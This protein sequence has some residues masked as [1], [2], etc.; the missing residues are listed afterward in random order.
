M[1]L[2]NL[3]TNHMPDCLGVEGTPYF[4]WKIRTDLPDTKQ[5]SYHI[6]VK[7]EEEMVW[8][9]GTIESNKTAFITYGGKPLTSSTLYR[10]E[11]EVEDS[12]GCTS[13]GSACFET[14]LLDKDDWKA[15][16][17]ESSLP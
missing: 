7:S 15:F 9:S 4:S 11:V 5:R 12:H 17:V 8:D 16:W 13:V 10:W 2:Y 6:T 14:A 3:T 1:E